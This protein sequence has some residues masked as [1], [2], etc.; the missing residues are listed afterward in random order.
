MVRDL[1]GTRDLP[2]L[3]VVAEAFER[4]GPVERVSSLFGIDGLTDRDVVTGIRALY[5]DGLISG[6][7]ASSM[8][9]FELLEIE[10]TGDGRRALGQWPSGHPY[11]ELLA[12]IAS[13]IEASTDP[14]ERS[15]LE[16]LAS[17]MK[18]LGEGV[19]ANL[20]AALIQR[21]VGM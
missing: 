15:R 20:L 4:S 2:L 19:V 12:L 6:I 18:G 5:Q 3:T 8:N 14:D 13:R 16:R 11:D 1:W 21:Q 10:L 9:D 7:D 17:A